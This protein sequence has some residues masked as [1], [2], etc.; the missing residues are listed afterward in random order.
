LS[1]IDFLDAIHNR[2]MAVRFELDAMH[3][4]A[5]PGQQYSDFAIK[6]LAELME[7]TQHRKVQMSDEQHGIV[8]FF[9]DTRFL[10]DLV[11]CT[12]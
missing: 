5:I 11:A 7:F 6:R 1:C 8:T 12:C 9:S 10:V 4:L 3:K 2:Y